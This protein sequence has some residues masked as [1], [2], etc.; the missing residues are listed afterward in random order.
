MT[1]RT[2]SHRI[3][4]AALGVALLAG[5]AISADLDTS[6]QAGQYANS[7]AAVRVKGAIGNF[8]NSTIF[9]PFILLNDSALAGQPALPNPRQSFINTPQVQSVG[10]NIVGYLTTFNSAPTNTIADRVLAILGTT[11]AAGGGFSNNVVLNEGTV[12]KGDSPGAITRLG[13]ISFLERFGGGQNNLG[14]F[15]GITGIS[16]QVALPPNLA[17]SHVLLDTAVGVGN[18]TETAVNLSPAGGVR[19]GVFIG[20]P[21]A[22]RDSLGDLIT[23]NT[24]FNQIPALLAGEVAASIN[25]VAVY[26]NF[27]NDPRAGTVLDP[28]GGSIGPGHIAGWFQQSIPLPT[29]PPGETRT[30]AR[31]TQPVVRN[32]T[33]PSGAQIIYVAHGIGFSGTTPFSGGSARPILLAVDTLRPDY[34]G[35]NA[36]PENNTILIEA[37]ALGAVGSV[38][39]RPYTLTNPAPAGFADHWNTD[40][41]MRFV[42]HVATGGAADV[43]STSRFDINAKGQIVAIVENRNL[44]PTQAQLRL[45]NP[46]W[47]AANNRITGYTL[48]A[49]IAT[50]GDLD[51]SS[52]PIA[53]QQVLNTV[54]NPPAVFTEAGVDT[55]SAPA[56]DDLGRVAF[57][58][59]TQANTLLGDWDA[60]FFTP[61]TQWLQNTTNTL[62]VWEPTTGSIH[63]IIRGGQLGDTLTD[64][65]PGGGAGFVDNNLAVGVFATSADATDAFGR[66]SFSA[67]G[68]HLAIAFRSSGNQFVAGVNQEFE[69]RPDLTNDNF[70]DRGGV[71]YAPGQLGINE[72]SVR[73]AL[74]V[75]LGAFVAAPPPCNG[76]AN[77]DGQV[78]FADITA[79]LSNWQTNGANGGDANHDGVV[80]FA[81]ITTVLS[82]WQQPCP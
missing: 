45:Y 70:I 2:H 3:V 30:D 58:G 19:G 82:N 66:G 10:G 42:D 26:R 41:N 16:P 49:I 20:T 44:V 46:T 15:T 67:A 43:S 1:N 50:N 27:N 75:T 14:V 32:V 56:I 55:I 38:H 4:T 17:P 51:D 31:Q 23:A 53:L 21:G 60:N 69:I 74:V 22:D 79:V 65:F 6:G 68:G 80:N 24:H 18:A 36:T 5:T 48:A 40:P 35:G 76:D 7:V 47:N 62:F 72:R 78:N 57:V 71:L 63:R 64:S 73:G 11:D 28:N 12:N 34:A 39:G 77:G 25:G 33:T 59:L 29:V 61:D 13:D 37:D 54:E 52:N 81:D 9:V 8:A